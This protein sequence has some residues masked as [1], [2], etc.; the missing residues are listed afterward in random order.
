MDEF[1]N[2]N[3]CKK[4]IRNS[5]DKYLCC[6][7]DTNKIKQRNK[8]KNLN[9]KKKKENNLLTPD[10]TDDENTPIK[11]SFN[12]K[13]IFNA[14][15][16]YNDNKYLY[17]NNT[18]NA[19]IFDDEKQKNIIKNNTI[20][21]EYKIYN[22][23]EAIIN[24]LENSYS[25][26]KNIKLICYNENIT[27]NDNDIVEDNTEEDDDLYESNNESDNSSESDYYR[28]ISDDD[29]Y[30][31][32]YYIYYQYIDKYSNWIWNELHELKNI[33]NSID[34]NK[35]ID[36]MLSSFDF[37]CY[38]PNNYLLYTTNDRDIENDEIFIEI[39]KDYLKSFS[40]L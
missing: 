7:H 40:S 33:N 10:T 19:T 37:L 18:L 3:I 29:N 13:N 16:V 2:L 8:I 23:Y 31:K 1:N 12:N 35:C 36:N 9:R 11:N 24:N 26:N 32:P 20:F 4:R 38:I 21:Y 39:K 28:Y 6:L 15:N 5:N 30:F 14:Y 22:N 27:S 34:R 17:C 25:R